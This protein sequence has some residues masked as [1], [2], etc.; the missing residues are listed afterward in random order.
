MTT[1]LNAKQELLK[2]A[3]NRTLRGTDF[4]KALY[5]AHDAQGCSENTLSDCIAALSKLSL[6]I[7]GERRVRDPLTFYFD[8][9]E[10]D[11]AE[12]FTLAIERLG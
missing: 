12:I 8:N 9:P 7:T 6:E 10:N 1:R 4:L 3:R 5:D 2:S 11:V